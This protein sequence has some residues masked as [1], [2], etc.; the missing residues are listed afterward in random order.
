MLRFVEAVYLVH[1]DDG[2]G[3]VLARP[4]RVGHHLLD[5]F[6]P[7][8]HRGKFDEIGMGHAGD[9]LGQRGFADAGRPPEKQRAGVVALDLHP[10]R[11]A[12]R[13]NVFLSD[14]LIQRTRAHAIG[15]RPR[16]VDGIV[17]RD[18]LEEIHKNVY[19]RGTE[20]TQL[21]EHVDGFRS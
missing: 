14:K 21:R 15:Q 5:F 13:E 4:F 20:N 10:Q 19:H 2:S 11:L 17:G 7:G 16:F 1:E 18:L 3:A 6:D 8:Q 12:G 9:D